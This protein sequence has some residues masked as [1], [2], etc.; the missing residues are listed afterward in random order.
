[1]TPLLFKPRHRQ[2][3][4]VLIISLML[5]IILTMLGIS[6]LDATKLETKMAANTAEMNRALQ[7]AEIGLKIPI[8][9]P[10]DK[11]VD[12]ATRADSNPLTAEYY[13]FNSSNQ[14]IPATGVG[15]S[16]ASYVL[17]V[18]TIRSN[19]F[20]PDKS[21]KGKCSGDCVLNFIIRSTG[22]SREDVNAPRVML[23][24]GMSRYIPTNTKTLSTTEE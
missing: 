10:V 21:G 24:G 2:Q 18:Q 8:N 14:L 7:V 5:L 12:I 4:A 17:E 15:A 23:R 9:Y 19:E 20:Y 16:S 6:A 22:R 13:R 11:I 1:M 3:G